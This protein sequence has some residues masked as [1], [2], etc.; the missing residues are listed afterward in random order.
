MHVCLVCVELVS[1]MCPE[2]VE[3]VNIG[4]TTC[5]EIDVW[6]VS[7][8]VCS[9]C[10]ACFKSVFGLCLWLCPVCSLPVFVQIV[11]RACLGCV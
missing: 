10:L 3:C 11:P 8:G 7:G 9:V 5:L 1:R 2:C 4:A 6:S